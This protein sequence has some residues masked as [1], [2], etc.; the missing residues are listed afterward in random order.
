MQKSSAIKLLTDELTKAKNKF[1][2]FPTSMVE[3]V[4]V[5]TEEAGETTQKANEY[6]WEGA[7]KDEVLKEVIQTGAMALRVMINWENLKQSRSEQKP[8]LD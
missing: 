6:N 3:A 4:A 2:T 8:D 5:M 1:P 7:S